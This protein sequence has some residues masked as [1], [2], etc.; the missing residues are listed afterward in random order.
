MGFKVESVISS[1][2]PIRI[3]AR[4]VVYGGDYP[5]MASLSLTLAPVRRIELL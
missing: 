3:A 5:L 4:P 1:A 2:D